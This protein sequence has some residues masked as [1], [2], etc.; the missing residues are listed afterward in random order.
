MWENWEFFLIFFSKIKAGTT[1]Q[2]KEGFL[3]F[4]MSGNFL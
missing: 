4:G 3:L 1:K 2:R